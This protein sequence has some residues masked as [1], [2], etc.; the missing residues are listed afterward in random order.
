MGFL[1]F[2]TLK[3]S[4]FCGVNDI[5]QV[6]DHWASKSKSCCKVIQSAIE[7]MGG[8]NKTSSACNLILLRT[9]MGSYR[10]LII[11]KVQAPYLEWLFW[12]SNITYCD[13]PFKNELARKEVFPGF[14]SETTYEIGENVELYQRLYWNPH[15]PLWLRHCNLID[16]SN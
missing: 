7:C 14:H 4:H 8:Y 2:V 12:F 6:C 11:V 13:L 16:C 10:S 1:L 3:N 9:Q 5:N 15:C